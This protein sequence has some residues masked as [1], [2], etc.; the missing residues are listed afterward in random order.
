MKVKDA[1]TR[2]LT[3]VEKG[4]TIQD[5]ARRMQALD[6]GILP[7]VNPADQAIEGMVTDRDI[8]VRAIAMG[9]EPGSQ[10]VESIMSHP[11]VCCYENDELEDASKAMKAR[12]VRRTLVLDSEDRPVGMLSLGDLA[13]NDVDDRELHS[14]LRWVSTPAGPAPSP[15]PTANE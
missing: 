2:K 13:K 9:E 8:V 7:I 11:L 4:S 1:M 5:A 15:H 14:L 12:Q 3:A 6:V 10:P